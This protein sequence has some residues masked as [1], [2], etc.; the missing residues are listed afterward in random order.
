MRNIFV[1]VLAFLAFIPPVHANLRGA[2]FIPEVDA[3]FNALETAQA[4]IP[5][6]KHTLQYSIILGSTV[7]GGVS[8]GAGTY[9]SG[10]VLPSDALVTDGF[11]YFKTAFNNTN[12]PT[13]AI[14]C[15]APGDILGSTAIT[16]SYSVAGSAVYL[17]PQWYGTA[18][19]QNT[20]GSP[21]FFGATGSACNLSTVISGGTSGGM[22]TTGNATVVLEYVL[23]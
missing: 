23:P 9:A 15:A 22:F 10:V 3:R 16:S 17:N 13:L 4:A 8:T 21:Q 20:G 2:P 11:I 14:T 18:L 6:S 12:N 5:S 7:S 1:A 19:H